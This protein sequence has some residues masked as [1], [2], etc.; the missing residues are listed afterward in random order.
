VTWTKLS[1]DFADDCE[2]LSD[3]AF[4]LHVE[5]L[6]WSNRKLLDCIIPVDHLRRFARDPGSVDEL[7][8]VGWWSRIADTYV[9]R[10]QATY[11]RTRE[12]VV[13]QQEA[14]AVNGRKGGRPSLPKPPGETQSVSDSLSD[15]QTQGDRTG[16]GSSTDADEQKWGDVAEHLRTPPSLLSV[17]REAS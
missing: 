9:I 13:R 10:H 3:A 5:G 11:Q 16:Q 17:P 8:A 6:C 7:L 14:N 12:Q 15:S 4:R 1:D 2:T